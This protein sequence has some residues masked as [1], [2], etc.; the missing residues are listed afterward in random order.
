VES[1]ESN[2][3]EAQDDESIRNVEQKNVA[4]NL[5]G[6]LESVQHDHNSSTNSWDKDDVAGETIGHVAEEQP[7]VNDATTA[8]ARRD[9]PNNKDKQTKKDSESSNTEANRSFEER[10]S[11]LHEK[12]E[13]QL[14]TKLADLE[15]KI[16][17]S[18]HQI[19][20]QKIEAS[21][22]ETV[23]LK[24]ELHESTT[25]VVQLRT[26]IASKDLDLLK[27]NKKVIHLESSLG[28]SLRKP[29]TDCAGVGDGEL[30][31]DMPPV[32]EEDFLVEKSKLEQEVNAA[33]T[34][35]SFLEQQTEQ[36]SKLLS[37]AEQQLREAEKVAA[38]EKASH[39]SIM[40]M[41]EEK[42]ESADLALLNKLSE[43]QT[44]SETAV[45]TMK[46][47][48]ARVQ[49]SA[50]NEVASIRAEKEGVEKMLAD[51]GDELTNAQAS[52]MSALA[53]L[54]TQH[55]VEM[56]S[57]KSSMLESHKQE[58]KTMQNQLREEKLAKMEMELASN[59]AIEA[60]E[61]AVDRAA[62]AENKLKQMTD[63]INETENLKSAN[64]K[65]FTSLQA[66]TEKRKI[67]HNTI[68]D[69]KGDSLFLSHHCLC[70]LYLC[71]LI[72][73]TLHPPHRTNQ[74]LC[75]SKTAQ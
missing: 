5:G 30:N 66:E 51:L 70:V 11:I 3:G 67:L 26:E 58:L 28:E 35:I 57:L 15:E 34:R 10:M 63:M 60:M 22:E 62:A 48:L 32:R 19:H 39:V 14:M 46:E 27:L 23:Q 9:E 45:N 41:L 17:L 16:T 36:T 44:R 25:A 4:R 47:E 52:H 68:E 20:Q 38:N 1:L 40:R 59:E 65:L 33:M 6:D 2:S 29:A 8:S 69:M 42:S 24:K 73:N 18:Q 12:M 61:K 50:R 7:A 49:V 71:V 64:D 21:A 74:S 37:D 54:K 75:A 13:A 55:E 53:E 43:E 72:K 56:T 31:P